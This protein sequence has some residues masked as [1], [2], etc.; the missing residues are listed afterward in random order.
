MTNKYSLLANIL[1]RPWAINFEYAQNAGTLLSSILN[2]GLEMTA[3]DEPE[4]NKPF[5]ASYVQNSLKYS[6]GY[7]DSPKGSVAVI[8][9]RGELMKYDEYCGPAGMQTIGKR[10]VEADNHPNISQI[11][12]LI[13]SPGGSVDGLITLTNIIK[14]TK[15]PITSFI[16]E[17]AASGAMWLAS[18]TDKTIASLETARLGSIGVMLSFADM[19]PFWELQGVKFHEIY[20]KHSGDKNKLFSETRKGDYKKIRKEILDPL[21]VEFRNAIKTN[22]PNVSDE[23]LTGKMFFAKDLIGTLVDEIASFEKAIEITSNLAITNK[24]NINSKTKSMEG[25]NNLSTAAGVETFESQDGGIFLS[26]DQAKLVEKALADYKAQLKTANQEIIAV[27]TRLE[28]ETT[29]LNTQLGEA[30]ELTASLKEENA[31]L[32]DENETL[33]G[34]PAVETT[35]AVTDKN[36]ESVKESDPNVTTGKDFVEDMQA[37]AEAYL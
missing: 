7:N 31:N 25:L 18:A 12:L 21:A 8:P 36:K 4:E 35:A 26:E 14:N 1:Y 29:A 13:D 24:L 16:D 10:I 2:P 28:E 23:H 22:R 19:Q 32:R 3:A 9:V 11:M 15:K 6:D 27:N 30:N 33:K 34:Q 5:A 20:S 17:T 37:V